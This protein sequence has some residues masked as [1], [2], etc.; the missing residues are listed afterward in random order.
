MAAANDH[1]GMLRQNLTDAGCS[2]DL[3]AECIALARSGLSAQM[4][5][6]LKK[7]RQGLLDKIHDTE[8]EL[9]CLDYLIY[10]VENDT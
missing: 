2:G 8:R 9:R 7:Q 6:R 5:Q 10:Q 4:L 1:E 3:T